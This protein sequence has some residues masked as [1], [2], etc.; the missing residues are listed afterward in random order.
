MLNVSD[1]LTSI[2]RSLADKIVGYL[3]AIGLSVGVV[4]PADLSGTATVA[5]SLG[6]LSL[7]QLVYYG[8]AR[9]IEQRWPAF[10]KILM[11]SGKQPTYV[12]GEVLAR[13][14]HTAP[15]RYGP[16]SR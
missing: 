14:D 4:L 15:S 3:V 13:R 7:A 6:L 2:A 10:G 8:I 11:L 1:I 16:G 9:V 12:Q 5:V